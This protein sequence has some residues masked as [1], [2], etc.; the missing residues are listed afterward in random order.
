MGQ[1][2]NRSEPSEGGSDAA[3][4]GAANVSRRTVLRAGAIGAA[5]AG[6]VVAAPGLLGELF[7][8]GPAP[9]ARASQAPALLDKAES[10]PTA[11]DGLIVAHIRDAATGEVSLYVEDREVVYRDLPLVQQIIRASQP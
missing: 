11:P 8:D 6:A 3:P 2:T 4:Q 7:S 9:S 1:E 5:A 10:A